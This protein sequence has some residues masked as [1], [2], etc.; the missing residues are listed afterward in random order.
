MN[1]RDTYGNNYF[2][3]LETAYIIG[4]D[5]LFTTYYQG[6]IEGNG[7]PTVIMIISGTL[8][9][10]NGVILGVKDYIFGKKILDYDYQPT[11]AYA[12]GTIE[13]KTHPGLSPCCEWNAK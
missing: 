12:P 1:T 4:H 13:I 9:I 11:N 8:V 3:D 5:N 10:E 2:L 6:K 7:N